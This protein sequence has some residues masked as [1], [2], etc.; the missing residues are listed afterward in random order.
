MLGG[1]SQ[2]VG[3]RKAATPDAAARRHVN[4]LLYA[5]AGDCLSTAC[6]PNASE[7]L[8]PDRQRP[9]QPSMST[10]QHHATSRG[11]EITAAGSAIRR[12]SGI[13]VD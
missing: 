13:V 6:M 5:G 8:P 1:K 9:G 3:A 4:G 10:R 11:P 7:A 2:R 12:V